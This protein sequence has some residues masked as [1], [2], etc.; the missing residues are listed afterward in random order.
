[1]AKAWRL[2]EY[3]GTD[4][5]LVSTLER[6]IHGTLD[7]GLGR[8]TAFELR[9]EQIQAYQDLLRDL[10]VSARDMPSPEFEKADSGQ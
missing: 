4:S 6:S 1:M 7:V 5:W 3:D 2:I 8:I 9:G 10:Q